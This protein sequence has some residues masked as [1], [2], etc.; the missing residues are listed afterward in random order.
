MKR[1]SHLY[2]LLPVSRSPGLLINLVLCTAICL[3]YTVTASAATQVDVNH[4]CAADVGPIGSCTAN[5]IKIADATNAVA[6]VTYCVPGQS[7]EITRI[8]VEYELNAVK[9][10]DPLLWVEIG[11]AHV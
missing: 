7:I 3:S 5:D 4:Q 1:F 9:R 11:R 8:N 6:A 2:R 10:Y